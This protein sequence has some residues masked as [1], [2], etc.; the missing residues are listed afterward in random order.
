MRRGSNLRGLWLAIAVTPLVFAVTTFYGAIA[1]ASTATIVSQIVVS[2][3]FVVTGLVAWA[4][5]PANRMGRLMVWFGWTFMAIAFT[6]PAAP[7]LLPLGLAGFIAS[8]TL[9]SLVILAY[10]SGELRAR[11]DRLLVTTIAVGIGA[12]R[13]LR[14]V[15]TEELPPGSGQPN[16]WF[17]DAAPDVIPAAS[18]LPYVADAVVIGMLL[19]VVLVR[20]WRASGPLRRSLSPV[21]LPTVALLAILLVSTLTV[22]IPVPDEV[23]EP[24]EVVQLFARIVFPIGFLVGILRTRMAR[25]AVADLVVDLGTTQTPGRLRDALANAL[26]DPS[27]EVGY[28]SGADGGYLDADGAHIELPGP[29]DARGMTL[30]ARDGKPLAAILHDP[31]LLDDPGLVAAVSSALRLAVENERLQAEVQS[32][33]DEVRASRSRIIAA[34]DAERKRVERDL[35]DGAQQRLVSLT[36]ALRLARSRAGPNVDPELAASLEAASAEARAAL[37]ELRELA[38]GIHPQI[39]TGS[40]LGPALGSLADRSPMGVTVD[41]GSGRYPADVEGAA[42]FAVSEALA[43]VAK[44]AQARNVSVRAGWTTGTLIIEVADDGIGGAD[45]A[46]GSGLRGLA[47]R[48]AAVD[49]SLEVVSPRGGGTRLLARIP[50]PGP[51][52]DPPFSPTTLPA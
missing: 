26:G 2:G 38:R 15:T 20:W 27:L 4:S 7:V 41:V 11:S 50:T 36:L 24:L 43:N 49:G 9:L 10:P 28:W 8:G 19:V 35:H 21:L 48:L 25:S 3:V 22:I 29:E 12:P 46:R 31:V 14:L 44:Y 45:A 30:L 17:L 33:L 34:G 18:P 13:I 5:R 16:P 40:G 42:Y 52:A 23:A 47:D 51:T 37:A 1:G 6:I 32:Q 39:L